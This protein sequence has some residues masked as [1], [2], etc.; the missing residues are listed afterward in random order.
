M[1]SGLSTMDT[2]IC[3]RPSA[4]RQ[5]G[6]TP[7]LRGGMSGRPPGA[8]VRENRLAGAR[9]AWSAGT[10]G[11]LVRARAAR[12]ASC[13]AGPGDEDEVGRWWNA[14]GPGGIP[15]ARARAPRAHLRRQV[16][17]ASDSFNEAYLCGPCERRMKENGIR[18]DRR[19]SRTGLTRKR[20]RREEALPG[21]CTSALEL[22]RT[23]CPSLLRLD[24]QA[25]LL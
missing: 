2:R 4:T 21:S 6:R 14:G 20:W 17:T 24:H 16:Q 12:G 23:A 18:I 15:G 1:E 22:A 19:H 9:E 5:S 7:R 13:G 25:R 11:G 3:P 10:Q 8:W